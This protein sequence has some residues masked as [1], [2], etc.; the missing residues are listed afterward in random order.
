[1]LLKLHKNHIVPNKCAEHRGRKHTIILVWCQWNLLPEPPNTD[2]R[3]PKNVGMVDWVAA[4]IQLLKVKSRGC[5]YL[6]R[7]IFSALRKWL[8]TMGFFVYSRSKQNSMHYIYAHITWQCRITFT[9]QKHHPLF[10]VCQ[11]DEYMWYMALYP[12]WPGTRT[13]LI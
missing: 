7:C 6:S 5:V 2:A 4:D 1:M 12:H 10:L 3:G 8:L 13:R 9:D 11:G